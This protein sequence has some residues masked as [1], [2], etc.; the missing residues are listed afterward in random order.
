ML[1]VAL[2]ELQDFAGGIKELEKVS[3]VLSNHNCE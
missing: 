1:G 2:V 3:I